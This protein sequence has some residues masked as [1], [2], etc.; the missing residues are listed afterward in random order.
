MRSDQFPQPAPSGALDPPKRRPP[1]AVGADASEPV[2]P[3]PPRRVYHERVVAIGPDLRSVLNT[4]LDR[5][6]AVAD[7]LA[8]WLGLRGGRAEQW[9]LGCRLTERCT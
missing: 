9:A 8:D 3:P 4:A 5:L 7:D 2:P 1:T 6:D